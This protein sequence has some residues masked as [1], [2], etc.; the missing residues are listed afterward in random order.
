ME[1][2][3]TSKRWTYAEFA[4]LP[5]SGSTRYEI[6]DDELVVTPSPGTR[7]QRIVTRLVFTLYGFVDTHDLGEVFVSPFDVLFA[8]GDYLE[9][10]VLFVR[11]DRA[12]VVTDR[13]IEGPPD[14]VVEVL[15]PSTAARDR[16]VKLDRYRLYGVPEYWIVDPHEQTVEVWKIGE[17]SVEPAVLGPADALKWQPV[18]GDAT[19]QIRVAEL[20]VE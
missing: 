4:R 8:E 18:A 14:F 10:D 2:K 16:G 13:G 7:H 17:G 3:S 9:P 12:D 20:F 15:S 5:E 19:L 11:K 1:A 6:I